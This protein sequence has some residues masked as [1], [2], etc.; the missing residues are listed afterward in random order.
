MLLYSFLSFRLCSSRL[1]CNF[2]IHGIYLSDVG[3][4]C[5]QDFLL[6][7]NI[8]TEVYYFINVLKISNCKNTDCYWPWLFLIFIYKFILIQ[9]TES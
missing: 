4:H 7:T 6:L 8:T 9:Q 2:Y 5:C 1:S 3:I